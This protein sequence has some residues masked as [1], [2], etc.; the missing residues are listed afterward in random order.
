MPR[1]RPS[2]LSACTLAGS[3]QHKSPAGSDKL[4]LVGRIAVGVHL[5]TLEERGGLQRLPRRMVRKHF[6]K[7]RILLQQHRLPCAVHLVQI[8]AARLV[9]KGKSG[10]A[11]HHQHRNGPLG[12][13]RNH[14]RH[15]DLDADRRMAELSTSPIRSLATTGV[16]P[17]HLVVHGGDGPRHLGHVL[18]HSAIDI[19]LE[20]LHQFRPALLPPHCG[21]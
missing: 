20:H 2:P 21:A 6:F 16:K 11:K 19:L 1:V 13:G 8:V 17:M 5:R 18:G 12:V 3:K 10:A 15:V 9:G 4:P 14:Q 7:R